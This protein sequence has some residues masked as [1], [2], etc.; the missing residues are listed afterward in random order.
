MDHEL[1][2]AVP[3]EHGDGS[4]RHAVAAHDD[5]SVSHRTPDDGI[6][7]PDLLGNIGASARGLEIDL[8]SLGSVVA[9]LACNDPG[10]ERGQIDRRGQKI[11]HPLEGRSGARPSGQRQ[12]GHSKG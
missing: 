3:T 1:H 5:G 10:A 2:Q 8:Q 4:H 6:A 9:S 12:D 11:R 7:D